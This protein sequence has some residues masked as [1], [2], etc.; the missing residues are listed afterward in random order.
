M[1]KQFSG[2][3]EETYQAHQKLVDGSTSVASQLILYNY[4]PHPLLGK[5]GSQLI[6]SPPL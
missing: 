1:G 4:H 6:K 5:E 3:S 2:L